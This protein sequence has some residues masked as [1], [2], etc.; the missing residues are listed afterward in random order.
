MAVNNVILN[1]IYT[2]DKFS[3]SFIVKIMN[4][5]DITMKWNWILVLD[6]L[7]S[8]KLECVGDD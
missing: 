7:D 4:S 5:L 6:E 3:N 1:P 8:I 2:L